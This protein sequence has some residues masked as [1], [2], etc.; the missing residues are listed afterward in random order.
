MLIPELKRRVWC[1]HT[2]IL[3]K[4]QNAFWVGAIIILN[5]L[6]SRQDKH[7]GSH[8]LATERMSMATNSF[9]C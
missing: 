2:S 7:P 6:P 3:K 5:L 4:T 1:P 9:D 8:D